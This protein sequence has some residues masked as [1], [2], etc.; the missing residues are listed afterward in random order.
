MN[1]AQEQATAIKNMANKL[2]FGIIVSGE[3]LTVTKSFTPGDVAGFRECDMMYY[4]VLELL[5]R[6]SAGSDWGT[7]GSG[8]GGMVSAKKG[9]F[10]MNRSGGSK[11]V[12]K[13]LEKMLAN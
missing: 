10:K 5:K 9:F 3:I 4:S 6:T 7:D 11:L 2:G 12:L 8:I 1:K 13:A